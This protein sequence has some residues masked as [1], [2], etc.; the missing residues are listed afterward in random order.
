MVK[1]Y[2]ISYIKAY[3]N[4]LVK[5]SLDEKNLQ[6]MGEIK[7]IIRL[8]ADKNTGLINV[9]KI[10]IIKLFFNSEKVKKS[11]NEFEKIDFRRLEYDFIINML[12]RN[13]RRKNFTNK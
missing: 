5:F 4:Q 2:S 9:I 7:D 11:Y 3:L 6:R 1:L 10:Y 13:N 8:I 12:E